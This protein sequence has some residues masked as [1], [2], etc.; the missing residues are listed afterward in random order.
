MR[1]APGAGW[2]WPAQ[3]CHTLHALWSTE[4][5][6]S[7]ALFPSESEHG[8]ELSMPRGAEKLQGSRGAKGAPGAG[9]GTGTAA[10]LL[11]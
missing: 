2:Q 3:S 6:T 7:L 5:L 11:M 1:L 4:N 10:A 8:Y 9:M